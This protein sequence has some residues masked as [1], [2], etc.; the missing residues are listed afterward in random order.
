MVLPTGLKPREMLKL[1]NEVDTNKNGI[2][3]PA[4]FD[5]VSCCNLCKIR[6]CHNSDILNCWTI[7]MIQNNTVELN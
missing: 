5:W 1:W 4:E 6:L 3:E 2:I 7:V